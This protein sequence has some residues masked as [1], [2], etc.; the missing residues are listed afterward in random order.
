MPPTKPPA[1]S[2]LAYWDNRFSTTSTPFDWLV[3]AN[4]L[5]SLVV[6][7]IRSS[8]RERCKILHIGCGSSELSFRLGELAGTRENIWNTDY[9]RVV[10]EQGRAIEEKLDARPPKIGHEEVSGRMNW[11]V[12]DL[13][14]DESITAFRAETQSES[15]DLIVDKSTS[16][17]IS[18]G[19]DLPLPGHGASIP[20]RSTLSIILHPLEVLALNLARLTRSGGRWICISY[21][22]DRF[23][24]LHPGTSSRTQSGHDGSTFCELEASRYWR[25]EHKEE[26]E[27]E[28]QP[29]RA[30]DSGLPGGGVTAKT[31]V[32][33]PKEVNYSYILVRTDV[34]LE[35]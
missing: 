10:I 35:P 4:A 6:A 8:S 29:E 33:R 13:L 12:L 19:P 27:V 3:S 11:T 32:F 2:D 21:S 30:V 34:L 9:S 14:S 20:S 17:A 26:I 31:P 7:S 16:D 25:L 18:C 24:F 5:D 28:A 22:S 1:F 15:F 23:G